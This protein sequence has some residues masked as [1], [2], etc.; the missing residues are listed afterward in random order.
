MLSVERKL[1]KTMKNGIML[2]REFED[3]N[4][5]DGTNEQTI[6]KFR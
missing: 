5:I 1:K 6:Q 4:A 3:F 2:R